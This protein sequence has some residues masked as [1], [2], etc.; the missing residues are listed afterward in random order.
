[1]SPVANRTVTLLEKIRVLDYAVKVVR[2]HGTVEIHAVP[3]SGEGDSHVAK[4]NDGQGE[5][6]EY[7]AACVLIEALGIDLR[8]DPN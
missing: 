7:R 5:V 1:M 4:C 6:E 8:D 3:L 2:G